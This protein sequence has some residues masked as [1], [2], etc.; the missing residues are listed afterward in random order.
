VLRSANQAAG[1]ILGVEL[2]RG[3]GQ[4]LQALAAESPRY[5]K[6]VA[7]VT[8]RLT[9]GEEEWREQLDIKPDAAGARVLVCAC[10]PL[11]GDE[12]AENDAE[13]EGSYVI[14]FDDISALLTAQRDAAWG[15][16]ARRL[17]H[18]IKNPLTPIQLSAERMRRRYLEQMTG[19]DAQILD[20]ATYTIVQQVEAMKAMV[21]AFSEYARAPDMKVTRF[22]FNALVTEVADLHRVHE[23]GVAIDVDLDLNIDQV[24]ADRGRVRQVLNNLIVNGAEAVESTAGGRVVV[25]TRLE[26]AGNASYATITVSDNGPGFSREVLG[27]V[28][29]PYVTSK[30]KGTGLGLAIVK[31]IAE[32]HGG[33]VEADNRP[34]GGGRVRVSLPLTDG[35]RQLVARERRAE[36]RK[37]RA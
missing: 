13:R 24:E 11:P 5:E 35:T 21:N 37:E 28:F 7:E 16:V 23:S 17:A 15:E 22:P 33:R 14:V 36:P 2:A 26:S 12:H 8:Q 31:K 29:D 9:K 19:E 3:V 4:P 27:R 20:R 30:P 18:E 10:T 32:E 6:F 34:E 1:N 25:A